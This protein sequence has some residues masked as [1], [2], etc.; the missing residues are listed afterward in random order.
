MI[1]KII[2]YDLL[3]DGKDT[4]KI[5]YKISDLNSDLKQRLL[6]I[7]EDEIIVDD[8]GDLIIIMTFDRKY[9]PLGSQVAQFKMDDFIKREEIEMTVYLSGLLEC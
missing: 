3:D 5:Q 8:D 2:S 7:I 6:S 1:T 9:Y 4:Y